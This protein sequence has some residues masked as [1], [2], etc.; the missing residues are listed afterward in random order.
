MLYDILT[1]L[2][3][4]CV[5]ITVYDRPV[6]SAGVESHFTQHAT[7]PLLS[8][9]DNNDQK[10][11]HQTQVVHRPLSPNTR[12]NV[13]L[14]FFEAQRIFP[15]PQPDDVDLKC[16]VGGVTRDSTGTDSGSWDGV[17][18]QDVLLTADTPPPCP[19]NLCPQLH[20]SPAD[21]ALA[22]LS[23]PTSFEPTGERDT[24]PMDACDLR[25]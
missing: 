24:P 12:F 3:L 19:Q 21:Q 11:T 2:R 23:C 16:S 5:F 22:Q 13:F 14:N 1:K 17:D 4:V 15:L 25:Y 18:T 6:K 9:L 10:T 20:S 8:M 7:D